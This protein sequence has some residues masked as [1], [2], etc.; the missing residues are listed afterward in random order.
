M[1]I[2]SLEEA[3]KSKDTYLSEMKKATMATESMLEEQ[4]K[5]VR[6]AERLLDD[7]K[8]L[9]ARQTRRIVMLEE[10]LQQQFEDSQRA[11]GRQRARITNLE[12]ELDLALSQS[13]TS[14]SRQSQQLQMMEEKV[15]RMAKAAEDTE[16]KQQQQRD[17]LQIEL[18]AAKRENLEGKQIREEVKSLRAQLEEVKM[19]SIVAESENQSAS[20]LQQQLTIANAQLQEA[21]KYKL[22]ALNAKA[23][24]EQKS[25]QISQLQDATQS[26]QSKVASQLHEKTEELTKIY[27]TLEGNADISQAELQAKDEALANEKAEK[28]KLADVLALLK[29]NTGKMM[30]KMQFAVSNLRASKDELRRDAKDIIVRSIKVFQQLQPSVLKLIE[31]V[32]NFETDKEAIMVKYR[33]EVVAR[34]LLYNQ[35]QE[36]KGNIRVF[37]RV[38]MDDCK[39]AVNCISENE[40]LIP[41]GDKGR[42][43]CYEFDR[44][45]DP[46][47]TQAQVYEDASSIIQSV[48]DG[49]NVCY[50]AYGQTGSG[51]TFTMMGP[52]N[53][54]DLAGVNRRAVFDLFKICEERADVD[55][56]LRVNMVEI[57]ND[58]IF[59][60]L[61][62]HHTESLRLK[63][64][65]DGTTQVE[66]MIIRTVTCAAD[67]TA[68][69]AEADQNRSVAATAM[70]MH[71]S[72]SHLVLQITVSGTNQISEVRTVGKLSLVDLAGSERVNK[73]EAKGARLVEAV[74]INKSLTSLG[75]IF[76]ALGQKQKHIPYRNSKLTH[77][78]QDSLGGDAK[79]CMFL[80]LSPAETNL[81]ET[82]GTLNFGQGIG[83]I[84]LGP[85]KKNVKK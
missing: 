15:A 47:A 78:L 28:Q 83:K 81:N 63:Q 7:Q 25:M 46:T 38:R 82:R 62:G 75:M 14:V 51:K 67:V 39:V 37:C 2:S 1:L 54:P 26:D 20:V 34:K 18:F 85:I 6:D 17:E 50:L 31:L 9:T 27:A 80:N 43:K 59:D 57:Y 42:T 35:I 49:Y 32:N 24:V 73:S 68:V 79:A 12:A 69:L 13:N 64:Q 60:L 44:V 65:P 16:S 19:T 4:S 71:S 33:Q 45:Y 8:S 23:E 76:N 52:P 66:D 77:L 58:N 5:E 3:L 56:E 11:G 84:E 22:E 40:V 21:E 61:A 36:L 48:T 74:Q 10:E 72:R 29:R 55:Y 41:V 30:G 70:N 53:D